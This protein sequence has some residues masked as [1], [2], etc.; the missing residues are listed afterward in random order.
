M[1]LSRRERRSVLFML[2]LLLLYNFMKFG[3]LGVHKIL[4]TAFVR[5]WSSSIT[6][7]ASKNRAL[8]FF[9]GSSYTYLTLPSPFKV[10]KNRY[11]SSYPTKKLNVQCNWNRWWE[12]DKT[13]WNSF[14]DFDE[15]HSYCWGFHFMSFRFFLSFFSASSQEFSILSL[16]RMMN[17]VF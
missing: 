11:V 15:I 6:L 2:L 1:W 9:Y 7:H 10:L 3:W 14:P 12:E 5:R 13:I 16:F 8:T 17:S 4:L